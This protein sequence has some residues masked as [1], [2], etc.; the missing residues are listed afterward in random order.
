MN[1]FYEVSIPANTSKTAPYSKPLKLT[2][3]VITGLQ[4][5]IPSGHAGTAHLLLLLHEFQLYPL[6]RGEDYHGDDVPITF[7]DRTLLDAAPYEL[8]AIGW[9]TDT[10]NAHAFMVSVEVLRL[11]EIGV[12]AG[13]IT[14]DDLKELIGH[15]V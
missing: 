7:A 11:D 15:E 3:G 13:F 14:T 1:F 12:G 10:E 2:Y 9:N 4:V 8:R 6:S 5:V